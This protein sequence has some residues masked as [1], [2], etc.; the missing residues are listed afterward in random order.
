MTQ[1]DLLVIGIAFEKGTAETIAPPAGWTL[2]RRE[3]HGTDAGVATY[4]KIAG[5]TEP[6]NYVFHI[7]NGSKWSIGISRIGNAYTPSP[8]DTSGSTTGSGS[9]VWTPSLT[10]SQ[11]NCLVLCFFTNKKA[12]TYTAPAST[13]KRYDAPY[14]AGGQPSNMMASFVQST[15][16]ATGV[17]TATASEPEFWVSMKVAIRSN[18]MQAPLPVTLVSFA[19]ERCQ[20]NAVCLTWRTASEINHES[21]T[22]QRSADGTRWDD[23]HTIYGTGDVYSEKTYQHSDRKP[24]S[25][26]TYYRLK[27]RDLDG[28]TTFYRVEKVTT[29]ERTDQ[30]L[31]V[32]AHP[33]GQGLIVPGPFNPNTLLQVVDMSGRLVW[34]KTVSGASVWMETNGWMNG[35]YI[36]TDGKTAVRF[37]K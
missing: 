27:Q 24:F 4:F 36:L 28:R 20:S 13:T 11:A 15:A 7:S 2:I 32:L 34:K 16:G 3:D 37:R 10:T 35:I 8:I 9:A 18:A 6:G 14:V 33:G 22:L 21:F 1:N 25:P 17:R 19:A 23:I 30:A 29:G 5:N 26:I 31:Q 12:A